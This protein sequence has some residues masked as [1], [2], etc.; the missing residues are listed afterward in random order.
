M[1]DRKRNNDDAAKQ[2]VEMIEE[3]YRRY[4]VP[5]GLAKRILFLRKKY[6][7]LLIIG[8]TG[9]FKRILD[10]AVSVAMLILLSPLFLI[11][12]ALIKLTDGGPVLFWQSR[13]GKWGREFP[14]PK[15]RSMVLNA[16]ELKAK[17]L[18]QSDHADSRTF[19]MKKDPR[20][21]WLGRIIR[22]LSIDE[23][24]QLWNVLIGDMSLVGPR[25]PVPKEVSQ[26]TLSDRRRLDVKPGL[27]CIWQISGRGDIPFPRQVELDVEY[28][29]SSSIWLDIVILVKTVPAVLFGKGAY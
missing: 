28:I 17:L 2:R 7:W 27:T 14:F 8:A 1:D 26:Y 20:I 6:L 9:L 5:Q 22:K 13:V 24:P 12:A 19:K 18:E 10:I 29:E 21:T 4:S 25:P 3:L 15:F 11:V 16:E 23:L